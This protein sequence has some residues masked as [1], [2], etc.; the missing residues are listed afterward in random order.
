[1]ISPGIPSLKR[2]QFTQ[3]IVRANALDKSGFKEWFFQPGMLFNS[4][5]KWWGDHGRRDKPHEGLDICLYKDRQDRILYLDGKTKIPSMVDGVIVKIFNDFL[6]KSLI[7]KHDLHNND[8]G[9]FCTI[10]GHTNPLDGLHVGS[11][12]KEGD[13]IAT[14]ADS[15][16]SKHDILPHLHLS[17]GWIS[18]Y[19]SYDQLD[20]ETIGSRNTLTLLDPLYVIGAHYPAL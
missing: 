6:G 2:T 10:Y 13:I 11:I 5:D 4:V 19:I 20:W 3:T 16:E 17:L 15:I 18:K 1:M 7:V 12:V 8:R 14:L 9:R